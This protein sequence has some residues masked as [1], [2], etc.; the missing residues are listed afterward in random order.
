MEANT[1]SKQMLGVPLV[2]G[3]G[4]IICSQ[5]YTEVFVPA[6]KPKPLAKGEKLIPIAEIPQ[7]AQPAFSGMKTLNRIQSKMYQTALFSAVSSTRIIKHKIGYISVTG[8][9]TSLCA[10][11]SGENQCRCTYHAS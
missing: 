7:W 10:N 9:F 3:V 2:A 1:Q 11:G 8:Q 5:G 6:M 4:V